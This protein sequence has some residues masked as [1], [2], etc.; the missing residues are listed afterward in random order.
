MNLATSCRVYGSGAGGQ[1]SHMVTTWGKRGGEKGKD[2]VRGLSMGQ[3]ELI[4][5]DS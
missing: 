1:G 5:P 3:E 2:G 4:R